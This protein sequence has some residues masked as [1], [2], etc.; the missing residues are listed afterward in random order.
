MTN[1][2]ARYLYN[3]LQQ[4]IT[5]TYIYHNISLTLICILCALMTTCQTQRTLKFA[6]YIFF[7]QNMCIYTCKMNFFALHNHSLSNKQCVVDVFFDNVRVLQRDNFLCSQHC[8][9]ASGLGHCA[10]VVCRDRSVPFPA[11]LCLYCVE[12]AHQSF[13]ELST[14]TAVNEEVQRV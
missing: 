13:P 12:H 5:D 2:Y 1:L 4:F 10:S 11:V 3:I 14:H 8:F 9:S 6:T 7:L